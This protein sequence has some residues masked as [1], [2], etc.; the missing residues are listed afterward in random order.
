MAVVAGGSLGAVMRIV[1]GMARI[2]A[3]LRR[4]VEY[5]F[6]VTVGAFECL[7]CTMDLMIG[8]DV[9]IKGN[10][11]PVRTRVTGIAPA[12][13]QTIVVIVLEVAGD[14]R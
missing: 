11:R 10:P 1:L 5:G 12:S 7:V 6:L 14:A 2:A 3:R 8:V 9:V 4:D 13:E